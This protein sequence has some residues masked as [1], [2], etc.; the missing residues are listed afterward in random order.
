M[1]ISYGLYEIKPDVLVITLSGPVGGRDIIELMEVLLDNRVFRA[2]T[3]RIWDAR[4]ISE[5]VLEPPEVRAV[6]DM[7][8]AHFTA[9]GGKVAVVVSRE[10]DAMAAQLFRAYVDGRPLEVFTD[11]DDAIRWMKR[12]A[13]AGPNG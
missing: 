3:K 1:R 5:L 6:R 10:V 12:K 13:G 11:M 2:S 7:A 9:L 4:D 8:A